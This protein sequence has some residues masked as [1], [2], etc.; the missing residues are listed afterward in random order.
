MKRAIA[1]NLVVAA[2]ST[3]VLA[4]ALLL[5]ASPHV[6]TLLRLAISLRKRRVTCSSA[7]TTSAIVP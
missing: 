3:A 1:T 6:A 4:G 2:V 7:A 5:A